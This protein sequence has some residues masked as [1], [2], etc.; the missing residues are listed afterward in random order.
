[1][2]KERTEFDEYWEENEEDID[3]SDVDATS[4]GDDDDEGDT[5]P[6]V[7]D[8]GTIDDAAKPASAK[9]NEIAELKG[10][11]S[12]MQQQMSHLTQPKK[13]ADEEPSAPEP[14]DN[15]PFVSEEAMEKI[16]EERDIAAFNKVLQGVAER[17]SKATAAKIAQTMPNLLNSMIRTQ[18]KAG[19]EGKAFYQRNPDMLEYKDWLQ[20]EVEKIAGKNPGMQLPELLDSAAKSLRTRLNLKDQP[21]DSPAKKKTGQPSSTGGRKGGSPTP[22]S[23]KKLSKTEQQIIDYFKE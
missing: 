15:S 9:D 4:D 10:M 21:K 8:D 20:I 13:K 6:D 12:L 22:T 17:S 14:D 16:F 11:I 3:T 23:K 1:M 5:D 19:D 7:E 18:L 2:N